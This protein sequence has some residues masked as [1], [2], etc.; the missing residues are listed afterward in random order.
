ML[1]LAKLFTVP[2][3]V[4]CGLA[5]I[6]AMAIFYCGLDWRK[7]DPAH[8][9]RN[10]AVFFLGVL[11]LATAVYFYG[12]AFGKGSDHYA[13]LF[14]LASAL[15]GLLGLAFPYGLVWVFGLLSLAAWMGTETEYVS[16]SG[17]YFLGMNYPCRFA[18][19][20]LELALICIAG[21]HAQARPGGSARSFSSRVALMSP[22]TKVVV[23]FNRF[24]ALWIM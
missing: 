11:S 1:L 9:Y 22:Q 21:E 14:L 15:Y 20:G 17:M 13:L 5:T 8:A 7:G 2:A 24:I 4:K 10:E 16:G 6:C 19:F 12:V 18:L 3:L 23:L